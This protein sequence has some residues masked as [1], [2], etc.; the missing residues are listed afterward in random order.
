MEERFKSYEEL[1]ENISRG[2]E[3]EFSY[4]GKKYSILPIHEGIVVVEQYNDDSE[5]IYKDLRD[6]GEYKI[7]DE[8]LKDIYKES[9]DIV[10]VLLKTL[11]RYMPWQ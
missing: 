5:V 6:I 9:R 7:G 3:V 10:Q 8:Y 4:N 11:N 2:G 1:I